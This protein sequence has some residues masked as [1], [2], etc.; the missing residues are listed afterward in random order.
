[1]PEALISLA[2][3]TALLTSLACMLVIDH[4][5]ELFVFRSPLRAA[6]VVLAGLMLFLAWDFGGIALGIFFQGPGPYMTG[7]MLAP[8]LPLEE[9]VFLTFLSHLT[10]VLVLGA[11]RVLAHRRSRWAD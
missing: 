5:F 6:A 1:M 10:M 9:I 7:I 4:R 8:E 2:Y 3:L 11:Q